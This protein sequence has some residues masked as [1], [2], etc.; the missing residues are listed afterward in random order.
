MRFPFR[1]AMGPKPAPSPEQTITM[2]A[3]RI[4]HMA[5]TAAEMGIEDRLATPLAAAREVSTPR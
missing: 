5:E 2:L 1:F 3:E 4:D